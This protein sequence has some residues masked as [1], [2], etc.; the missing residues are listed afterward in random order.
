MPLRLTKVQ[1]SRAKAKLKEYLYLFLRYSM[2]K[3]FW[4]TMCINETFF[5]HH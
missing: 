1:K 5:E 4:D 2:D 3:L